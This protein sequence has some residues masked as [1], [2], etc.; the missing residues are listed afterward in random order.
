M[1]KP[2]HECGVFGIYLPLHNQSERA[3]DD[4]ARLSFFALHALQHRG[5]ESAGIATFDGERSHLYK[6]MGLVTQVFKEDNLQQLQGHI[7]I[8]HNRYSTTGNSSVHNAQP[9]LVETKLGTLGIAHNGNLT[10]AAQLKQ[11]LLEQGE[12][13]TTSSDTEMMIKLLVRSQGENW[14]ERLKDIMTHAEGAYALTVLTQDALYGLRDPWGFRPLCIGKYKDGY[15]LASE[16][17]AF[18]TIGAELVD[19]VQPG[20]IVKISDEGL[21]RFQGA[22]SQRISLCTFEHIYF[23]RPDSI[24]QGKVLHQVRQKLGHVL[25]QESPAEADVVIAVPDSGTPA[26]IGYAQAMNLPF[27]EGLTKNRYIARTFIQPSNELR[28]NAVSLKFNPLPDNLT[29]KRV[30]VVDDSIVRGNTVGPLIKMIREGGASEVHVRVSSPAIRY[31]CFMG[32]D[33]AKQEELVAFRLSVEEICRKVGADSLAYLSIQGMMQAVAETEII[34]AG[35]GYCNAC[36]TG[37]YPL[38]IE[39]VKRLKQAPYS[40]NA[41]LSLG[42]K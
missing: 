27:T 25:A 31:P 30:V 16:S 7:A 28:K 11:Q 37:D 17:C 20:E 2:Q 10:N 13:F 8:A 36:F 35:S 24:F 18:A 6:N 29:G 15:V 3:N 26:A 19:E 21:E 34:G 33:M 12:G 22:T 39:T 38:G 1:D 5:Q 9:Y 4:V 41:C 42:D 32:V 14:S 40:K 23:A